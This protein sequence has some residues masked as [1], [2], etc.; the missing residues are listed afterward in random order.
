[1][2]ELSFKGKEFLYNHHLAVP[3]PLH[4]FR[5]RCL[6]AAFDASPAV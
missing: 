3:I 2:T 6:R 5:S 4:A 1:M